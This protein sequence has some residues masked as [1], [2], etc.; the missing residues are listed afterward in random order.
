MNRAIVIAGPTGVGKTKTSI[1]L[2]RKLNA[3]VISSDSAQVYRGLNIGT[4]KIT[5]EE[6]EGIKHHLIDIVDPTEKYSV[7]NF[8][9]INY[10][11]KKF[12]EKLAHKKQIVIANKMDLIWDMKKYNKF[13]DYLAEKGIEIYPVS[14]LLNE[15][16]KEVLYKTYDMLS[17][18]EREPLEEETD[19]TKLLKE[20]KIEKEDFE[21]TRDQEDAIVVGGRIVDDVLAKYVIG[22]DD[23]SLVTFLHM[24]R[25]LGMEEALQE[26]GVQDGDTVKIADVEFEYFE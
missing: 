23:E 21:I 7:G 13:K 14:V 5:K 16:L 22:M 4:A 9:K 19:I 8:E 24:M 3:E 26:F 25:N 1:D 6:T 12:S 10:E 17:H 20:L 15:G 2:A 18:I 11:L